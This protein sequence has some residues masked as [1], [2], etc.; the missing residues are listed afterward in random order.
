M[1]GDNPAATHGANA[2]TQAATS[3]PLPPPA[4]ADRRSTA[5]ATGTQGH[6]VAGAPSPGRRPG[7]DCY[8]TADTDIPVT[9]ARVTARKCCAPC[10]PR[11]TG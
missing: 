4:P 7:Q 10:A 5:M 1:S 8:S 3:P 6:I 9:M 2:S 11:P